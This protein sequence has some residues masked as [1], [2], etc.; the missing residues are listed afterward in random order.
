MFQIRHLHSIVGPL[1]ADFS[2][3]IFLLCSNGYSNTLVHSIRSQRF[4]SAFPQLASAFTRPMSRTSSLLRLVADRHQ[5]AARQTYNLHIKCYVKPN[6]SSRR[7]GVT[8]VGT[9]R[10]DV[11]VAAAPRD[12]AANLAVSQ[13]FAEVCNV[14]FIVPQ[15][16]DTDPQCRSSRFPSPM[17][18]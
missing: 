13:V 8:S 18:R 4:T 6:S 17:L 14:V 1:F 9:D 16:T 11:S 5:Y 2:T 12:G 3:L 10:L 7:V 15:C